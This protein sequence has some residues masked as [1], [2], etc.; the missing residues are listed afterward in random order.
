MIYCPVEIKYCAAKDSRCPG[1]GTQYPAEV[2]RDAIY[3]VL[4]SFVLRK[5]SYFCK[6]VKN[7]ANIKNIEMKAK[8]VEEIR[9]KIV[10]AQSVVV[11]DYRGLTVEEVT[12]LRKEMRKANIE[13]AV[14]KNHLFARAAEAEG[15]DAS[16][17]DHLKGPSAFAFGYEDAV[18]PAKILRDT[19]KKLKK[20]EIKGGI[21]DGKVASA[22]DMNT[23][24]DLPS[25][26][27]LIARLLGS[28]MSPISG[29]AIVLDQIAKKNGEASEAQAE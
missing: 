11:I 20:C 2:M 8:Q 25:R 24:A 13:Y 14:L 16:I 5:G 28:M 1:N 27:Q 26:E 6:E 19:L 12:A 29:L 9:E 4:S 18:A 7:L 10:K 23:L 21:I 15:V 22:A 17:T 3:R